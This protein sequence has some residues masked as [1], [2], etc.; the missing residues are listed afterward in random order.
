MRLLYFVKTPFW[1]KWMYRSCV[2]NVPSSQNT[3][4]FTFDDGPHP[5]ATP[6]VLDE[7]KK[8]HAKGTFFCIGKN[9]ALYP[10]IYKRI[11]EEGHSVGNHTYHHLNGW[12]TK[13]DHY[14]NDIYQAKQIIDSNLFRPPYGRISMFQLKLLR[15]LKYNLNPIM[16]SILSGDFDKGLS[17][18]KCLKNVIELS[19]SGDIVVFHDSEKAFDKMA[20]TLPKALEYFSKNHFQFDKIVIK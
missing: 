1:L 12:K 4:Y 10:D 16:W 15:K 5:L 11:I 20:Y 6:F 3:L 18:E 14:M 8:Y 7:L 9:V 19:K 2:W 13:D 17:K